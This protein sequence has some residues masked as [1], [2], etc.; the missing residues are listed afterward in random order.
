MIGSR[1]SIMLAAAAEVA[2]TFPL[3]PDRVGGD[4]SFDF[5][6]RYAR[7]CALVGICPRRRRGARWPSR[8]M[9]AAN[10]L[11]DEHGH[12]VGTLD[13][14]LV[15][16]VLDDVQPAAG[17]RRMRG[18][19]VSRGDHAVLRAGDEQCR[20]P[21]RGVELVERADGLS[22]GIDYRAQGAQKRLARLWTRPGRGLS[23][24]SPV[25]PVRVR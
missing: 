21:R 2:N 15:A 5:L 16:R 17:D 11:I 6:V 7:L 8:R 22:T 9:V 12:D 24:G 3:A 25:V 20:N 19:R 10:E 14:G 1:N 18:A 13:L 23:P 4:V